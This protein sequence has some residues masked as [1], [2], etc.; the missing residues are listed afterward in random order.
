[1]TEH[2][3]TKI[4]L[5]LFLFTSNYC[6]NIVLTTFAYE[7]NSSPSSYRQSRKERNTSTIHIAM[8]R[9][10]LVDAK[11]MVLGHKERRLQN[12]SFCSHFG[13]VF[14]Y[15]LVCKFW[16]QLTKPQPCYMNLELICPLSTLELRDFGATCSNSSFS[17]NS[18]YL[19]VCIVKV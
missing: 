16:N 13:V 17:F 8:A 14:L 11:K 10:V 15:D 18:S 5:T 6:T 3:L 4:L 12:E 1:M 7:D 19:S 9:A 2:Y